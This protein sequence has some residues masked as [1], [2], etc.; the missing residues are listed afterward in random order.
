MAP[1]AIPT[2]VG[3]TE[4]IDWAK[5]RKAGHPHVCGDYDLAL[6]YESPVAGPSPRVWGL[7]QRSGGLRPAAGPSPRVW[8]LPAQ[9]LLRR[10]GRRAIPTCVGTTVWG[11]GSYSIGNGPSPRVWGL[12]V[13][14]QLVL[15]QLRAIPTCV[16]T[17]LGTG[18]EC[19]LEA[20][21]PHVCGDYGVDHVDLH[22]LPR[23]IPTCV[24]T[25]CAPSS[26]V[27]A[28]TGH[29]HVC[30]DYLGGPGGPGPGSRAIPTCV[31]TTALL[32]GQSPLVTG[33]PHV[34]GDYGG[35]RVE[36]IRPGGPS[37][38]VWGLRRWAAWPPSSSG[39]SPRVWGL[40][41][42]PHRLLAGVRAIPTCVG[43]TSTQKT[44]VAVGNGPSPR[45]WGLRLSTPSRR[46][47]TGPS[48]RVWGLHGLD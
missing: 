40:L 43:T 12:R 45:V 13:P 22:G 15:L 19:W 16:G 4:T 3:T 31:G 38:R 28:T 27:P 34:C 25:T 5:Y 41:R 44:K 33:H 17:T 18:W 1:R 24:G 36:V 47:P 29:P 37:P 42:G 6:W 32:E 20:G 11:V 46:C 7:Q 14:G 10:P 23:A 30:G 48:P 26:G 39:P 2:C 35:P 9:C 21:H 8:G